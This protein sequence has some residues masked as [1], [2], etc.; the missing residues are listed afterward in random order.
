MEREICAGEN[1]YPRWGEEVAAAVR[2]NGAAADPDALREFLL[3]RLARHKVPAQ[4]L[5]VDEF[6]RT[7]SGKIQKS[8]VAGW[9]GPSAE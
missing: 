9:F 1:I 6:P 3:T 8:E 4:W 5:I 7:A 2:S